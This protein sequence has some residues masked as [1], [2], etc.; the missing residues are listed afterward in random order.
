M[1]LLKQI[2]KDEKKK[3]PRLISK[4]EMSHKLMDKKMRKEKQKVPLCET[5]SA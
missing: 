1:K 2:E 5:L 4:N 3:K